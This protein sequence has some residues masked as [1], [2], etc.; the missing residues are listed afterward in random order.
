[1]QSYSLSTTT[2]NFKSFISKFKSF[3]IVTFYQPIQYMS[4]ATKESMVNGLGISPNKI[5][6]LKPEE[7]K[8]T[9]SKEENDVLYVCLC[10]QDYMGTLPRFFI[11]YQLE[12]YS[13]S[14]FEKPYYRA[15]VKRADFVFEYSLSNMKRIYQELDIPLDRVLWFPIS[16]SDAFVGKS[17]MTPS[18]KKKIIFVGSLSERRVRLMKTLY[19]MGIDTF[20][21]A[22]IPDDE[23]EKLLSETAIGVNLRFWDNREGILEMT[24]VMRFLS[25]SIPVISENSS[26]PVE[27][28]IPSRYFPETLIFRKYDE[29]V[30]T[31]YK[32]L[33][34]EVQLKTLREKLPEQ[35]KH[36]T[37]DN[38]WKSIDSIP[39]GLLQ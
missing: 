10:M 31:I 18:N 4:H 27:D 35:V 15:L 9:R 13:Y 7:F 28:Y 39:Q 25:H 8:P 30:Y 21:A 17:L 6:I 19:Y 14:Q 36:F 26:D 24:R 29:L 11:L 33:Q 1:M 32:L 16:H 38:Q 12:Q 3:K 34:D 20:C 22:S 23:H 37:I 5:T 2:T